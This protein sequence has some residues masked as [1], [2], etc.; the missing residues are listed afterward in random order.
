M[1]KSRCPT[2][3]RRP[4]ARREGRPRLRVAPQTVLDALAGGLTVTE[5]AREL[6]ISRASVC[7]LRDAG[8]VGQRRVGKS[9]RAWPP[10]VGEQARRDVT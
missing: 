1:T 5:A 2:C 9:D 6:G 10:G 3:G 7:R 4:P 8:L